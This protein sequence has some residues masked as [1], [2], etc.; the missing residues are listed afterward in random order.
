M[1]PSRPPGIGKIEG[2]ELLLLG[3]RRSSVEGL[4]AELIELAT[5]LITSLNAHHSQGEQRLVKS[6]EK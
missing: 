2:G 3:S 4:I 1:V 5:A 6:L